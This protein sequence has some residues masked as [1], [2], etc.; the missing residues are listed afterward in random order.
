MKMY[1]NFTL[2]ELTDSDTARRLHIDNTPPTEAIAHLGELVG[3]ILQPLREAWGKPI[4][5]TSGYR[6]SKLNKAVGGVG[7]SAHLYGWAAD[8]QPSNDRDFEMFKDFVAAFVKGTGIRFDQII[9]EHSASSR[10]VHIGIRN[11]DGDQ[12]GQLFRMD[13]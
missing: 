5:I 12:R 3:T 4:R 1:N 11:K 10:W 13:V 9:E 8:C 7:T 2:N 6:C